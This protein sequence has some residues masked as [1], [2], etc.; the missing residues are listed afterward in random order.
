MFVGVDSELLDGLSHSETR[1]FAERIVPQHQ[2]AVL[3]LGRDL[4]LEAA[5]VFDLHGAEI[6]C[7]ITFVLLDQ[8]EGQIARTHLIVGDEQTSL[9]VDIGTDIVA[10]SS[11]HVGQQVT[12]R[13]GIDIGDG[14]LALHCRAVM[15]SALDA[16]RVA[17][18]GTGAVDLSEGGGFGDRR[19]AIRRVGQCRPPDLSH[20]TVEGGVDLGD[21]VVGVIPGLQLHFGEF[22]VPPRLGDRHRL[23]SGDTSTQ[24]EAAQHFGARRSCGDVDIIVTGGG[25]LVA[26]HELDLVIRRRALSDEQLLDACQVVVEGVCE[27]FVV[28]R[29][30]PLAIEGDAH[31]DQGI[32][33]SFDGDT[34]VDRRTQ[35]RLHT[36]QGR[37]AGQRARRLGG[38]VETELFGDQVH[39]IVVFTDEILE[40]STQL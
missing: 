22:A 11:T 39:R 4:H 1:P 25:A 12:H 16:D 13:S 19:R 28:D 37:I 18:D 10:K 27:T 14:E 23:I 40:L 20:L 32:E 8:S 15:G 3:V 17:I 33:F 34:A 26:A 35:A 30:L 21:D 36:K 7:A 24:V 29:Q 9:G 38:I 5:F 6:Q 2:E 31:E